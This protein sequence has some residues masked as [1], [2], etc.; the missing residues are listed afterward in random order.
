M[1]KTLLLAM[2]LVAQETPTYTA[3]VKIDDV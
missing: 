2:V 1:I 3:R